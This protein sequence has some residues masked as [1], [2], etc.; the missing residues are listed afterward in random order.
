M[1]ESVLDRVVERLT[2]ALK[3][4]ANALVAPVSLLW[5]DEPAQWQPVVRRVADRIPVVTLGEYDPDRQQGPAYWVRCVVARTIDAGLPAGPPI[6]YLPGVPRGEL[7]A[8][9]SCP[10]ELAPIAELQYRS[11]EFTQPKSKRE[12]SIRAFLTNP[13]WGL[14][15]TIAHGAETRAALLLALDQLLDEPMDRLDRQVLDA[16]FFNELVNP[17]P[18]SILLG[19]LD[20]PPAYRERLRD[21]QW[22]A[23]V[24]QCTSD[25]GFHPDSEGPIT[26]ARKLGERAGGWV[27]VWK[28]FADMPTRYPGIVERLHQ[29]KP[30]E[31]PFEHSDA[32]PQ[33]NEAAEDQLRAR[34]R[35]FTVLTADGARKEAVR[36]DA[37]HSWRRGTV[38]ADLG[39]AQ[40][41][42]A[43]EQLALLAERTT[44][45]IAGDDLGTLAAIYADRGWQADDAALRAL[46]AAPK[47][48]D[49]DAVAA[50]VM[51]MY[52]SWLDAT[53]SS[54]QKA[55]GP[56]ANAG[57]YQPGPPVSPASG[58]VILFVDGLRLDVAHRVLKRLAGVSLEVELATSLAAL[59][60]VTQTSK[61]TLIPV[62]AGTLIGGPGLH[63]ANAVTGAR[64]S[65]HVL[66]SLMADA[67]VQV[68][69][70]TEVG[71]SAG[72]AWTETGE[73]DH[74]GHYLGTGLVDYLDENVDHIIRRIRELLEAGWKRV[75]V[76][77]DHGWILLPANMEKVELPPTTTEVK[78][79][80]C[81]RLKEGAVVEVPTVPWF[82][83]QDVRIALAPGATCFEAG[84]Q[85]EH[86]GVSPQECVVPR[87]G[88]TVG[89]TQGAT[90]GPEVTKI[91]WLGLLCRIE[92]SGV[93]DGTVV[94]LRALPGDAKTS[95]AEVAK[96]TSGAGRVS[97][98][99]PDEE[100]QGQRAHLVLISPDGQILAQR[101]VTVGKNR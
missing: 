97:L 69:G 82:W 33:D 66:R 42:F 101:T 68:L 63:A 86:G 13:E 23:F 3:Y 54:F 59:P 49:R 1:S 98:L 55:I 100:H 34:L 4:N 8:V 35:D 10:S 56:M 38:W 31:L 36:L 32:W 96:E 85:Y 15:L 5:P 26:A 62:A 87:I 12:W 20:N 81:A 46:G 37:E 43:V 77:T 30:M 95:I 17:D 7:R 83:D 25:L 76:V 51:A 92:V 74:R 94:D 60:T 53:A 6:V 91:T 71:D 11:H 28:R 84:K 78:K 29:A 22:S 47:A 88:I 70:P 90:S 9:D 65:I 64:A 21:A 93:G 50:A 44:L 39:L 72:V 40:L 24:Q 58:K 27:Q 18:I 89:A 73:V 57:T 75:E 79:G 16:D 99:V 14:G 61:P 45:H 19:W 2:D 48:A 52:L 80:R 41:A 67:G